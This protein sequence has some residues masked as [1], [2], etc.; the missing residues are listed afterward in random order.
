MIIIVNNVTMNEYCVNNS[1]NRLILTNL[2]FSYLNSIP[3]KLISSFETEWYSTFILNIQSLF[4][5]S[6]SYQPSGNLD[7]SFHAGADFLSLLFFY[8]FYHF[9]ITL[10]FDKTTYLSLLFSFILSVRLSNNLWGSHVSLF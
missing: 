8:N 5:S 9:F 4:Y 7:F 10:R 2:I 1:Q 6:C 3:Y